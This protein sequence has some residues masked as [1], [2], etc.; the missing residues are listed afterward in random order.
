MEK[1][2]KYRVKF[3]GLVKHAPLN[4]FGE[5]LRFYAVQ[6]ILISVI[7]KLHLRNLDK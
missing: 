5:H 3:N 1:R 2:A 4:I 7:I 6:N